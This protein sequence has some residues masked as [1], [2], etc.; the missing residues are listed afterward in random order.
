MTFDL[1]VRGATLPDGRKDIDIAARDGRIV[2]IE[3]AIAGEAEVVV[4]ALAP[5]RERTEKMLADEAQLDRLLA[6][7]AARAREIASQT[8]DTVRNRIGFL[9]PG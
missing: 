6:V 4:D 3:H 2:A 1:L 5:I 7:G 9:P 8:M